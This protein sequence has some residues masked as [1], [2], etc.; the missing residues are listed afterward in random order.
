MRGSKAHTYILQHQIVLLT[1]ITSNFANLQQPLICLV[2]NSPTIA[3]AVGIAE[4]GLTS[5][6]LF[7]DYRHIFSFRYFQMQPSPGWDSSSFYLA[8]D[9]HSIT[10]LPCTAPRLHTFATKRR[11]GS[12]YQSS[13][14][15][16]H[17]AL[18]LILL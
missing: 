18:T 12:K 4:S 2:S 5:F 1:F 9:A 11:A 17:K 16:H 13:S 14:K 15:E 8:Q 7:E 10:L 6:K 3:G